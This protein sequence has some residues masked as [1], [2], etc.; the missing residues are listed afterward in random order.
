LKRSICR[1]DQHPQSSPPHF[2]AHI[3]AMPECDIGGW[4]KFIPWETRS[5]HSTSDQYHWI[6][7][8]MHI[9]RRIWLRRWQDSWGI[10]VAWKI[11]GSTT[12]YVNNLYSQSNP[13][14]HPY[15][16]RNAV[17]WGVG[18]STYS[19]RES[20]EVTGLYLTTRT[21]SQIRHKMHIST[22]SCILQMVTLVVG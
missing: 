3:N 2:D 16:S 7:C 21:H 22:V 15:L 12:L 8:K 10:L 13:P 20:Q 19:F 6:R 11:V 9:S 17:Q 5:H 18:S 1:H 4:S 14:Q